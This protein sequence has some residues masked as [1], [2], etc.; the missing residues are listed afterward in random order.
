MPQVQSRQQALAPSNAIG[1]NENAIKNALIEQLGFPEGR[2]AVKDVLPLIHFGGARGFLDS[3]RI[4]SKDLSERDKIGLMAYWQGEFNN[5]Y[6]QS[7]LKEGIGNGFK[8][9][10]GM[11][12]IGE[13]LKGKDAGICGDINGS[14]SHLLAEAIGLKQSALLIFTGDIGHFVSLVKGREGYYLIDYND[15]FYLGNNLS[16]AMDIA[17]T[18]GGRFSPFS[19]AMSPGT[20]FD[21][22]AAEKFL[23]KLSGLAE[24]EIQ[25]G[26]STSFDAD[27]YGNV[28]V[29]ANYRFKNI[30]FGAFALNAPIPATDVQGIYADLS[31]GNEKMGTSFL[32]RLSFAVMRASTAGNAFPMMIAQAVPYLY[33]NRLGKLG[34]VEAK[35]MKVEVA[36]DFLGLHP[37]LTSSVGLVREFGDSKK[38]TEI[39]V[40]ADFRYVT[41]PEDVYDVKS[42]RL[43]EKI[44]AGFRNGST[45]VELAYKPESIGNK[46]DLTAEKGLSYGNFNFL[47]T[48]EGRLLETVPGGKTRVIEGANVGIAVAFVK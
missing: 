24:K 15:A 8:S 29:K 39:R 5:F 44:S 25:R 31:K 14:V 27:S 43:A 3:N 32:P 10:N 16:A 33:R 12:A 38:P 1:L 13:Y 22:G 42:V 2:W 7:R 36:S 20:A 9:Y 41:S 46:L 30:R 4:I 21:E 18:V 35:P 11:D 40:N 47:F 23:L 6:S 26:F 19:G 37:R 45:S 48:L 17:S 34:T 28:G